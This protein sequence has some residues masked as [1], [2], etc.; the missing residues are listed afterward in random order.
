MVVRI[1]VHNNIIAI[2]LV[3]FFT[4]HIEAGE[5]ISNMI[6]N[7]Y[8][9]ESYHYNCALNNL[10]KN[11]EED[12]KLY[13][14]EGNPNYDLGKYLL[15]NNS[16]NTVDLAVNRYKYNEYQLHVYRETLYRIDIKE[17]ESKWERLLHYHAGD[18]LA[19]EVILSIKPGEKKEFYATIRGAEEFDLD[20]K[21]YAYKLSVLDRGNTEITSFPYCF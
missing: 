2:L 3:I 21:N 8:D 16:S 1:N 11:S 12:I 5:D 7:G 13:L 10:Y 18:S 4:S 20:V 17:D 14:L 6:C 9:C 19:P 15:I